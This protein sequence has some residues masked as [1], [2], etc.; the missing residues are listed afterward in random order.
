VKRHVALVTGGIACLAAAGVLYGLGQHAANQP[1]LVPPAPRATVVGTMPACIYL[2]GKADRKCNPGAINPNV[3]QANIGQTIC[4]KYWTDS[5]RPSTGKIRDVQMMRYGMT[6]ANPGKEIREDHII[7]L[8]LGGSP[9]NPDNL[10]P[11]R[12]ADSITKDRE[13]DRLHAAVCSGQMDLAAAQQTI[14]LE[15]TH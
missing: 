13:E 7:S 12:Y 15:W 11:Q 6:A 1:K 9:S 4:K 2:D 8:E 3:T 10:Y 14:V 5:I